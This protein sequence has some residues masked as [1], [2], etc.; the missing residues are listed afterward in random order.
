MMC[1]RYGEGGTE[2]IWGEDA[3]PS[4][5]RGYVPEI[6]HRQDRYC[7]VFTCQ[8]GDYLKQL[9]LSVSEAKLS[10]YVD[11][12]V[13]DAVR[14]ATGDVRPGTSESGT[15]DAIPRPSRT[16]TGDSV[17]VSSDA[18]E[19]MEDESFPSYTNIS[20]RRPTPSAF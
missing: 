13:L 5:P 18:E 9:V 1:G 15:G 10:C 6:K 8:A 4:G 19:I 17:T 20:S 12:D 16:G 7:A 3:A 11:V 2:Q 14:A